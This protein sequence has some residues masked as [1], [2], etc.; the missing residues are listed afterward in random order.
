MII[1]KTEPKEKI[2]DAIQLIG[3][4]K[5]FCDYPN[6]AIL[7]HFTVNFDKSTKL[8]LT[9]EPPLLGRYCWVLDFFVCRLSFLV[10][11]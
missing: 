2:D 3:Y 1:L 7:K 9:T 4:L 8:D 5:S 10:E 11:M 6:V